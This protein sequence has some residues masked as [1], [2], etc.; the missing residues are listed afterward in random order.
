MTPVDVLTDAAEATV[1]LSRTKGWVT[2]VEQTLSLVAQ[3]LLS[4][5]EAGDRAGFLVPSMFEL[6]GKR[7]IGAVL[8]LE[9]RAIFAWV[10]G[11]IRTKSHAEVVSYDSIREVSQ[12]TRSISTKHRPGEEELLVSA[13]KTWRLLMTND[14]YCPKNIVPMVRGI[15]NGSISAVLGEQQGDQ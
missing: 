12:T 10:T 11:L 4:H 3:Q 5:L 14:D 8:L 2:D 13:A 9:R 15:L 6:D 7:E 1:N